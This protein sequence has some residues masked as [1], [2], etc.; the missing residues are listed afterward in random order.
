MKPVLPLLAAL[1]LAPLFALDQATLDLALEPGHELALR[2]SPWLVVG[3]QDPSHADAL[4]DLQKR[5]ALKVRP[6]LL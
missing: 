1:L 4:R 3:L 6:N 2:H 5:S